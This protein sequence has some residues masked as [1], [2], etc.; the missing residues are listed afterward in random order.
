ML[1]SVNGQ[2]REVS[3]AATIADLVAELSGS[4]EGRGVAVALGGE[5][6]PRRAWSQTALHPGA[7]VEVVVAVQGG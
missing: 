3:R 2:D 5:V 6:V 1:V 7:C 4:P